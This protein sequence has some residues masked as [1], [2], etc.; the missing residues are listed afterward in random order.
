MRSRMCGLCSLRKWDG[1][2]GFL[3]WN[4][5]YASHTAFIPSSCGLWSLPAKRTNNHQS[6]LPVKHPKQTCWPIQSNSHCSFRVSL[7]HFTSILHSI[8]HSLFILHHHS[9]F[10]LWYAVHC[11]HFTLTGSLEVYS[12]SANLP[13]GWSYSDQFLS[14]CQNVSFCLDYNF[15][16]GLKQPC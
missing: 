4:L 15:Y 8:L 6:V 14:F 12:K 10:Y 5:S 2:G 3:W 7:L 13:P 9:S 11:F 16:C 1:I